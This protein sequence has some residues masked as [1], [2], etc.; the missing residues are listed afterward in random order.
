MRRG[1]I[2][3]AMSVA[4]LSLGVGATSASAA[5]DEYIDAWLN[6]TAAAPWHTPTQSSGRN[7]S[8]G[9]LVCVTAGNQDGSRSG[10]DCTSASNGLA[11]VD[12]CGC[13]LRAGIIST[14]TAVYVRGRVTF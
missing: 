14:S 12:Y 13:R 9:G 3:V 7:V 10:N 6:G 2:A 11:V 5:Y 4:L 8:G 1:L